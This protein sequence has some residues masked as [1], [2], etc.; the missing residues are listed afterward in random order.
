MI[1]FQEFIDVLRYYD[2]INDYK[3]K[4]CALVNRNKSNVKPKSNIQDWNN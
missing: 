3:Y 1:G 2:I 4:T